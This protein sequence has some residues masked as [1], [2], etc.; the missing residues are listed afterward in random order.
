MYDVIPPTHDAQGFTWV[1]GVEYDVECASLS[2]ASQI[3]LGG[4]YWD[5][6]WFTASNMSVHFP[7]PCTFLA[8]N[9]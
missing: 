1:H 9:I 5:R 3:R 7:I 2:D 8:T 4:D 6:I